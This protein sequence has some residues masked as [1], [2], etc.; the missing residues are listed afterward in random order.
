M[1]ID[2]RKALAMNKGNL[3]EVGCA[4]KTFDYNSISVNNDVK[5]VM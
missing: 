3:Y 4:L 5:S 1:S 2:L